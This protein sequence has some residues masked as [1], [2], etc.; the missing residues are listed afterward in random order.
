M[1]GL[2]RFAFLVSS[3]GPLFLILEVKTLLDASSPLI[4]RWGMALAF[5]ASLLFT[6]L[7]L[8]GI[9]RSA[10]QTHDVVE[11]KA[12]DTDIFPYLM[13]YIPSLIF[14]DLYKPEVGVPLA[15]LYLTVFV[16]YFRIDSPY[17]NPYLA[18]LGFRVHEGRMKESRSQFILISHGR[19]LDGVETLQLHEVAGGQ[20]T[21]YYYEYTNRVESEPAR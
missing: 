19:A 11:L 6:R 14:R 4:A 3:F 2:Y 16:L 17:V 7:I 18:L 9:T 5:V 8:A 21:V 10:P 15:L 20:T 13:T 1:K 12:K